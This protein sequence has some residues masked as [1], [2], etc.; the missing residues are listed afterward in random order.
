[1]TMTDPIADMLSRVRNAQMA[2][3]ETVRIP[4]SK[5]KKALL[6]VLAEEG[7]IRS[8]AASENAQGHAELEV[9]LKYTGGKPVISEIHRVSRP[10]LRTYSSASDVP[11]MR[12]GLGVTVVSTSRGVMTDAKARENNVGGEILCQVF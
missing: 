8:V 2:G 7:Y 9:A 11:Q 12:N 6:E 5:V 10:G 3:H 1:M 4:T